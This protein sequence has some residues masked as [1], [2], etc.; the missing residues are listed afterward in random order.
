MT[1]EELV[2]MKN[3]NREMRES[4]VSFKNIFP[5]EENLKKYQNFMM[6]DEVQEVC[7]DV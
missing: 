2:E 7:F 6:D 3:K 4:R 1:K 5:A